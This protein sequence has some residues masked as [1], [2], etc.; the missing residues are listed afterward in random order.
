[1]NDKS[2]I[3]IYFAFIVFIIVIFNFAGLLSQEWL[4]VYVIHEKLGKLIDLEE[5]N[6]LGLF[7]D[8][9]NF[10]YAAFFSRENG[11]YGVRILYTE[12]EE[13]HI[14]ERNYTFDEI[15]VIRKYIKDRITALSEKPSKKVSDN[16]SGFGFLVDAGEKVD[17]EGNGIG[18]GINLGVVGGDFFS[19]SGGMSRITFEG[20]NK[21]SVGMSL[22]SSFFPDNKDE[23]SFAGIG[24]RLNRTFKTKDAG[25][26]DI[27]SGEFFLDFGCNI[28]ISESTVFSIKLSPA[29]EYI[30]NEEIEDKS[31]GGVFVTLGFIFH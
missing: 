24:A 4:K 10:H 31:S 12:E 16:G 22:R 14:T 6:L 3:K 23:E 28:D 9:Q 30:L 25:S 8:V 1:M 15:E 18:Y 2:K 11:S 26:Q 17:F 5:R 20:K 21:A 19:I 29:F 7:G 27:D 13:Q